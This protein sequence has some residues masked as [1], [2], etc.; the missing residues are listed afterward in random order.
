MIEVSPKEQSITAANI[1]GQPDT[2]DVARSRI[3]FYDQKI[4]SGRNC[5]IAGRRHHDIVEKH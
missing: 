4:R 2:H 3:F 5:A 1:P